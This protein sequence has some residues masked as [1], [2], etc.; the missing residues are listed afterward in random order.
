MRCKT[1]N[2][3]N[4]VSKK[5]K[6]CYKCMSRLWREKNPEKSAYLNLKSNAKRRGKHFDLTFEDFCKFCVKTKYMKKR[7]I[8]RMSY[9]V[10][11]IDENK[12]YT[13]NNIQILTNIEN[14]KKYWTNFHYEYNHIKNEMYFKTTTTRMAEIKPEDDPF[15]EFYIENEKESNRE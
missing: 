12:G 8:T 9:H 7:G 6:L 14:V 5:N 4:R 1:D 15:S 10:D 3:R 13:I 11:R 2:C